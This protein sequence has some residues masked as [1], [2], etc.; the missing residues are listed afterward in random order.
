LSTI[1]VANVHDPQILN[2]AIIGPVHSEIAPATDHHPEL[3][4]VQTLSGLRLYGLGDPR[5]P[6]EISFTPTLAVN[7]VAVDR[8][9]A[10]LASPG[11]VQLMDLTNPARLAFMPIGVPSFS[12]MQMA[13]A[14]G[15]L[16]IAD[17]YSLRVFG[18]NTAPPAPPPTRRRSA[19]H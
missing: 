4:V 1:D 11:M 17:R 14:K 6:A 18:P 5:N 15:K 9:A 10:Y 19:L 12:P 16:V 7:V 2:T 8:D 3:L 13:A